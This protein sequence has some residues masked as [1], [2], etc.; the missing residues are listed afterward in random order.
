MRAFDLVVEAPESSSF[1]GLRRAVDLSPEP[2]DGLVFVVGGRPL[3][4]PETSNRHDAQIR[5]PG[6]R[7]GTAADRNVGL[8]ASRAS[9]VVF[10]D[11]DA[12]VRPDWL[13]GITADVVRAP[14]DV[15]ATGV[16]YRRD[17]L[18]EIGGFDERLRT[19]ARAD[20]DAALRLARCGWRVEPGGRWVTHDTGGDPWSIVRRQWDRADDTVMRAVHGRWW[21]RSVAEAGRRVKSNH[22]G[23]PTEA[24]LLVTAGM[25]SLVAARNDRWRAAMAA[26]AC[27]VAGTAR[28]AAT[29]PLLGTLGL[30]GAALAASM[31][32]PVAVGATV[33]GALR[34][35]AVAA[36]PRR[37][38]RHAD[39]APLGAVL[40]D[41]DGTLLVDAPA[42]G[43]P[44][45]MRPTPGAR[46]ALDR[47][48]SAGLAV[49]MLDG[50]RSDGGRPKASGELLIRHR[51]EGLLG[52]FDVVEPSEPGRRHTD[53]SKDPAAIARA[54]RRLGLD[55]CRCA[56]VGDQGEDIAAGLAAGAR[57]VLVPNGATHGVDL[58]W[59]PAVAPT[60]EAAV[61]LLLDGVSASPG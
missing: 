27:W 57:A 41:R 47:V 50:H 24:A 44:A 21:R 2:M 52:P 55:P 43:A 58:R 60:I 10:L 40:F 6:F 17:A 32:P 9:W 15:A 8:R 34:A 23:H 33:V 49:G 19:G 42:D 37:R 5:L 12:A 20:D 46:T 56:V 38:E 25:A 26:A 3:R 28:L 13:E 31:I 51:V 48:R 59:V 54:A 7:P 16:A 1:P 11:R 18:T 4:W 29:D 14:A 39:D 61:D 22:P 35:R 36:S 53:G 45:H 30:R